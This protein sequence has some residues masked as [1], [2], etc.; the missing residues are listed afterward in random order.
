MGTNKHMV[1]SISHKRASVMLCVL[2]D[3]WGSKAG[4]L[5]RWNH[6]KIRHMRE[7]ALMRIL[8]SSI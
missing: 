5:W 8:E 4:A 1:G 7:L 2:P 6:T 3:C